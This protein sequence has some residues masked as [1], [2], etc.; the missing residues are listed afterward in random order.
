MW[1]SRVM[2]SATI[3]RDD[4][5]PDLS[6]GFWTRGSERA[7]TRNGPRTPP[8]SLAPRGDADADRKGIEL[9]PNGS[10][11]VLG[12]PVATGAHMTGSRGLRHE[13][14]SGP[15]TGRWPEPPV[16]FWH[17]FRTQEHEANPQ[18]SCRECRASVPF[19]LRARLWVQPSTLYSRLIVSKIVDCFDGSRRATRQPCRERAVVPSHCRYDLNR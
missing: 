17:I 2:V 11:K 9:G 10:F 19:I 5:H 1:R 4:T 3:R 18:P 7:E 16:R 13:T 12:M 8:D 6:S 15:A 14:G